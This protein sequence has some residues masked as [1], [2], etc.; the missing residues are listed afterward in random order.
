[1][2]LVGSTTGSLAPHASQQPSA[3]RFVGHSTKI[4]ALFRDAR[5]RLFKGHELLPQLVFAPAITNP[6]RDLIW[7][8]NTPAIW[9]QANVPT[10]RPAPSLLELSTVCRQPPTKWSFLVL[11]GMSRELDRAVTQGDRASVVATR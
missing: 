4:L 3:I 1:M 11:T 2:N 8:S 9:G 7:C 5:G 10:S 6:A